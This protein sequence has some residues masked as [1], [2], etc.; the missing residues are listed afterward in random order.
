M[1]IHIY[2]Y[3]YSAAGANKKSKSDVIFICFSTKLYRCYI[4]SVASSKQKSTCTDKCCISVSLNK[5]K[6]IER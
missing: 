5:T 1:H 2:I 3:I 6:S 4:Y